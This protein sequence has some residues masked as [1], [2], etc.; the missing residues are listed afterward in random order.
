MKNI[1]KLSLNHQDKTQ[2]KGISYF[3]RT[4]T[5]CLTAVLQTPSLM[6]PHKW[7]EREK[8]QIDEGKMS[9]LMGVF[10]LSWVHLVYGT[11]YTDLIMSHISFNIR[12]NSPV[13][14]RLQLL[15]NYSWNRRETSETLTNLKSSETFCSFLKP[16]ENL[17][18][19][20]TISP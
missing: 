18:Y 11:M 6:H 12:L 16:C 13:P 14:S 15:R 17:A 8:K 1:A 2:G 19:L 9:S 5:F 10:S 3:P 7:N 4:A 20:L